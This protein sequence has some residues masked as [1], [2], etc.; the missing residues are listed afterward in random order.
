MV[1]KPT[2]NTKPVM[3]TWLESNKIKLGKGLPGTAAG[4]LT[5]SLEA[6]GCI[7][8]R[9]I[10]SNFRPEILLFDTQYS[11]KLLHSST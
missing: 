7:C 1:A 4:C 10:L 9:E 3:K 11:Q 2:A 5:P 6:H 8:A